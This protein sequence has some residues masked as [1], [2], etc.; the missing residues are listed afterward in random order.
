LFTLTD[1]SHGLKPG[2]ITYVYMTVLFVTK[3]IILVIIDILLN[4]QV[5]L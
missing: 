3:L 1:K 4:I 2:Q 5:Y